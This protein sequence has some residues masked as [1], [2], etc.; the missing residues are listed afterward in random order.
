[1]SGLLTHASKAPKSPVPA[2]VPPGLVFD[3]N[4]Y[5][6]VTPGADVFEAMVDLKHK[7]PPVFWS[8]Y[9]GGHWY[10]PDGT[11]A[12]EVFTDQE[13]FSS[14]TLML[15]REFNPPKGQ[16]FTPIH[17]DQPEHAVYRNLLLNQLS[18]KTVIQML[19]HMRR[20]TIDL[21][22]R[23]KPLGRCD[24]TSEV[25]YPLPTETFIYL[26]KLPEE[27]HEPI[28]WRIAD[29]HVIEADKAK[30][31]AEI[32]EILHP[33]VEDRLKNP[34]DDTV[35]WLAQQ[36]INGEPLANHHIHSIVA[37]LLIAGLGTIADTYGCIFRWLADNPEQRQ[38][39]RDH[40]EQMNGVIN[41]LIRR[42]PVIMGGTL[43]LCVKDKQL[44]DVLVRNDDIILATP[45]SMNFDPLVYPDPLEVV[46]D[47]PI[48]HNGS[49]G[50]GPHRCAGAA[51][52]R[53][54][55]GIMIEEWLTRIPDFHVS[56]E[57]P[58]VQDAGVN[59]SY[60]ELILE[61]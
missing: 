12:R 25:A 55:L 36:Q 14:Q 60:E 7:A 40:P 61:W 34:G 17:M 49:F 4:V 57:K 56:K 52:S 54:L 24:F 6:P 46:F 35:S 44:G 37:L 42:F 10:V 20:F 28:K 5:E 9:N 1:M 21:I 53:S 18:R 31:F 3:F 50:H 11:L 48:V 51:L 41:E 27:Y 33:F 2:H 23:L 39:I 59:V 16:G 30:L 29:L 22:E 13:T 26:V 38:W 43:R 15:P 19:P 58:A 47:R 32:L 8:Q 45:A